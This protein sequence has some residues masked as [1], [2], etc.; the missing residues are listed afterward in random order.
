MQPEGGDPCLDQVRNGGR[1]VF[2]RREAVAVYMSR[3]LFTL[4]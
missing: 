2:E 4:L 1:F 3:I